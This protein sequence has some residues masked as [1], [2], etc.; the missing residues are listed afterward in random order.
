M[1]LGAGALVDEWGPI[2]SSTMQGQ[3]ENASSRK[4]NMVSNELRI[5]CELTLGFPGFGVS[6]EIHIPFIYKPT[7]YEIFFFLNSSLDSLGQSTTYSGFN[8]LSVPA[9]LLEQ[10][11]KC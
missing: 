9:H 7:V 11:L 10:A 2:H 1:V 8:H 6:Y 5:C 4:H 3:Q